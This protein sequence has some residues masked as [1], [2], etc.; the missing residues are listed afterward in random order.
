[1]N[2][3]SNGHANDQPITK[4][5]ELSGCL[6]T[7]NSF[8]VGPVIGT[9]FPDA[10]VAEWMRAENSDELIRDLA[11]TS[12]T[13]TNNSLKVLSDDKISF[14]ARSRLFP[15]PERLYQRASKGAG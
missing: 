13:I 9:E 14:S 7:Y 2:G 10:N 5:Y 12:K 11:I 6:D 1:M 8:K 3:N 4:H 15:C